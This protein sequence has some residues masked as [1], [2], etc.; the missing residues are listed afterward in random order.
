MTGFRTKTL[1]K[2]IAEGPPDSATDSYG[3]I[4]HLGAGAGRYLPAYLSTKVPRVVICE[5]D[6]THVTA[7]R[8]TAK[9]D[10]RVEILD[11]AVTDQTGPTI[12]HRLSL[13]EGSGLRTHTG[14]KELY[15]GLRSLGETTVEGINVSTLLSQTQLPHPGILIL[16]GRGE[17]STILEQLAV[18]DRLQDFSDVILPL[19]SLSLYEGTQSG[20]VLRGWLK[21]QG[22]QLVSEDLSDPDLPDVHF[23]LNPATIQLNALRDT[24]KETKG[25]LS[26]TRET[27][28]TT[29]DA[30]ST[31]QDEQAK[32]AT[33][34]KSS[35]AEQATTITALRDELTRAQGQREL[36]IADLHDLQARYAALVT[37]KDT[38]DRFLTGLVADLDQALAMLAAVPDR[39]ENTEAAA[40]ET[41]GDTA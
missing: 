38:Q 1:A 5:A 30:L 34:A 20:E 31:A 18:A 19:P 29:Q 10:P 33:A 15:P 16:D 2:I 35:A 25:T 14:L 23:R 24:L 21:T 7:L 8:R 3:V 6:P 9:G 37:A 13:S 39:E 26:E 36:R 12:L 32:S 22:Y 40:T 4:L 41:A 17:E 11:V 27:L 28:S